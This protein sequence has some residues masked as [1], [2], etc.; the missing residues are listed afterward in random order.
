MRTPL[1]LSL[2]LAAAVMAAPAASQARLPFAPGETCV[3]RGSAGGLVGRFGTGTLR[4]TGPETIDGR[5]A[6]LLSFDFRGRLALAVVEDRTRS[7]L[8][9]ATMG[10]LRYTKQERS[11]LSSKRQ[12]V[13]M[14]GAQRRWVTADG[15]TGET[16][17]DAPLDELSFLFLLRTLPLRDGDVYELN[18]HFEAER[19]PVT[20]RVTGRARTRV[21]AG[22]FATVGVE[23]RVRDPGRYRNERGEGVIRLALTDDARRIPVRIESSV[24]VVGRMVL[25]L[26]DAT[27][28]CLGPE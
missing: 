13:R 14:L 5:A 19:N 1:P 10:A 22:E 26:Q 25:A 27:P 6:Y 23:M 2:A 17:T 9:P 7:W 12:D 20:V 21:P 4:V 8:D 3:Y 15:R 18:R 24:P 16:T 11:P 28:E